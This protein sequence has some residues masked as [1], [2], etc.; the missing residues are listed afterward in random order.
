MIVY[1]LLA[2]VTVALFVFYILP[3]RRAATL[4]KWAVSF[5]KIYALPDLGYTPEQ[6][7]VFLG[8]SVFAGVGARF[9]GETLTHMIAYKVAAAREPYGNKNVR[10]INVSRSKARC[11]DLL[12]QLAST[13]PLPRGT[14]VYI[15]IGGNDA[16]HF[17]SVAA[18]RYQLD[19]TLSWLAD[20]GA[21]VVMATVPDLSFIPALKGF[22][23]L[24]NWQ[25]KRLNKVIRELAERF[26]VR[27]VDIYESKLIEPQLYAMDGFH[28]NGDGYTQWA[29]CFPN[30][31]D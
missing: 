16:T 25:V 10:V 7:L 17:T 1:G 31:T 12:R 3:R 19:Q 28:A 11:R 24:F 5:P 20:V 6:T 2:A 21:T 9:I 15:F 14:V 18:F 27:L 29:R 23:R 22:G 13:S 8:D 30:Q 4:V 26:D